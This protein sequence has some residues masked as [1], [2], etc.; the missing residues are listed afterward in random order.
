MHSQRFECCHFS[1]LFIVMRCFL[2]PYD[3]NCCVA[4]WSLI[5]VLFNELLFRTVARFR[6]VTNCMYVILV[7]A[8]FGMF[9][10]VLLLFFVAKT[11]DRT[12]E[13]SCVSILTV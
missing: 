6:F 13:M 1:S 11:E 3:D 5:I 9:F 2:C 7:R 8:I 10:R 12:H 4:L